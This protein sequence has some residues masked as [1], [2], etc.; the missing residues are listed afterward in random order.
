MAKRGWH[1]EHEAHGLC[2]R[3]IRVRSQKLSAGG[4]RNHFVTGGSLE[5]FFDTVAGEVYLE[6]YYGN[7]MEVPFGD[8]AE[9]SGLPYWMGNSYDDMLNDFVNVGADGD[10]LVESVI[11]YHEQYDAGD[12][13]T[14][15]GVDYYLAGSVS[16]G[17]GELEIQAENLDLVYPSVGYNFFRIWKPVPETFV[18]MVDDGF[19]LF[20]EGIPLNI[21]TS[22]FGESEESILAFA[23]RKEL[24]LP[25]VMWSNDKGKFVGGM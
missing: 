3:G 20:E 12:T 2:A 13:I 24:S 22:R 18:S 23:R 4:R 15:N 5:A 6:E 10:E 21:S 16:G 14:H 1:G 8:F 19:V 9:E 11:G 17:S 7:L 25:N